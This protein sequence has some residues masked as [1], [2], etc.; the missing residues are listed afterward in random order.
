MVRYRVPQGDL[1]KVTRER[2][3]SAVRFYTVKGNGLDL[4]KV[5]PATLVS[6][7]GIT[8]A[9]AERML[10]RLVADGRIERAD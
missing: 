5:N 1:D 9:D 3:L 4:G 2:V 6:R 8:Q 7:F 10:P